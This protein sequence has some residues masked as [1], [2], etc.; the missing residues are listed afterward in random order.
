MGQ[1][2]GVELEKLWP[3]IQLLMKR[4]NSIEED[5]YYK[6]NNKKRIYNSNSWEIWDSGI[7]L[8]I[9]DTV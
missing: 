6:L 1:K 3:Y 8:L 7:R 5:L 2:V 4:E 9:G